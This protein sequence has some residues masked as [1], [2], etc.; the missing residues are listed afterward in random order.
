MGSKKTAKKTKKRTAS[1]RSK[2]NRRKGH[3]FERE[4]AIKLRPL[5][6]DAKRHL[7]NQFSEA[8]GFDLDGTGPFRFQCKA[9]VNYAPIAKIKEVQHNKDQIPG[10]ITKGDGLKPV[11]CLY[12]DDFIKL[13]GDIGVAFEGV[14]PITED[15]F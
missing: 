10:L 14:K 6:P 9:Y 7:E 3:Q 12:L 8:L 2:T 13:L 5:Y 11:V 4:C 1:Q 15:D